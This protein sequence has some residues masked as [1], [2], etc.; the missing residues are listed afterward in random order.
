[1]KR[2]NWNPDKNQQLIRDRGVSFEDVVFFILQGDILDNVKHP[3]PEKYPG[4]R[5]FVLS[6]DDYVHL[7]PYFESLD[8]IFLKTIIPSRKATKE[9]LGERK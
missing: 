2:F 3:N 6:I 9:Y 5:I 8:E 7:V 1:M 4:Q